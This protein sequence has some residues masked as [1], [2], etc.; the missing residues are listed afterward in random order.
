MCVTR[1]EGYWRAT[2]FG[3]HVERQRAE[4]K[5]FNE[6][7][8][9]ETTVTLQESLM[10]LFAV[11]IIIYITDICFYVQHIFLLLEESFHKNCIRGMLSQAFLCAKLHQ[12]FQFWG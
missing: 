10:R 7:A 12:K 3:E 5:T 2:L 11:C 8:K 9:A 1:Q 6:N 4:G